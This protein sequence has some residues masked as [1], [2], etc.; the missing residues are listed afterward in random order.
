VAIQCGEINAN[1]VTKYHH[2]DRPLTKAPIKRMMKNARPEIKTLQDLAEWC[3]MP[4]G[5]LQNQI[6]W[7]FKRFANLTDYIKHNWYCSHL[8]DAKYIW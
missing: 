1:A 5:E 4:N 6:T 8:N 2:H 3:A 7:V